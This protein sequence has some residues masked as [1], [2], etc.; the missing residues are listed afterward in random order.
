MQ[1]Q[2]PLAVV[3]PTLDGDV[4]TVLAGADAAFTPGLVARLLAEPFAQTRRNGPSVPGVRNALQRL[5]EQGVVDVE[6]AGHAHQYRLN[7]EHL[8]AP[9]I[10]AL[11]GQFRALLE[12]LEERFAS[13]EHPP[14]YAALF[15]SAAR[16]QMRPGSDLDV[17][18]VRPDIVE[19]DVW[20]A[21]VGRL[22]HDSTRWTGN[23]TRVLTMTEDEVATAA[24]SGDP[25][26]E[27]VQRE[28]LVL[29]GRHEWL[30][31]ALR[32]GRARR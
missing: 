9:A 27:S 15:G 26:L 4:L 2:R 31:R 22:S 25:L 29:A 17:F 7:R 11:S 1:S 10:L 18:V 3:T 14:V 20:E 13:W 5:E 23:D 12:R 30:R 24:T 32:D 6:R 28:G 8:A 16:Q 19:E 21:D